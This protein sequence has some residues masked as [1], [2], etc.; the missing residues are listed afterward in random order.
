MSAPESRVGHVHRVTRE[1]DVEVTWVL[2]GAGRAEVSTGVK[3]LD[4]MLDSLSRHGF[5]DLTVK[6]SGDL[7]V[8]DHHTVEDVAITLGQALL[9]AIDGGAGIRRFGQAIVPMD[10]ARATAA[11]DLS[12][13]GVGVIEIPLEGPLVGDMKTQMV[14]HFFE[15]FARE[16]KMALHLQLERGDNDH[17]RVEV[18]FKA[19]AK[20]LDQA[21]QIEPRLR[22]EVPSTKGVL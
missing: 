15:S 22:G 9:Q 7:A 11:I 1:T 13:R 17:H 20:A 8:D 10:E 6:A 16:G 2:D 4:H 21:T 5:F 18:S 12:G 14:A 3:F 19:L